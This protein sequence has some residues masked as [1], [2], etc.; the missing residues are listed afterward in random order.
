MLL[1]RTIFWKR[2]F[3][4]MTRMM[5]TWMRTNKCSMYTVVE[6]VKHPWGV[7]IAHIGLSD[8]SEGELEP[9]TSEKVRAP[10]TDPVLRSSDASTPFHC[11][12]QCPNCNCAM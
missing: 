4:A 7:C 9:S 12:A 11:K 5:M 8:L 6:V 1:Y 10:E 3:R 2:T